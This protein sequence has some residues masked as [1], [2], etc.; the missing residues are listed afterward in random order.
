MAEEVCPHC[1]ETISEETEDCP[2]CGYFFTEHTCEK[3]QHRE[4]DGHC[5][6][7]GVAVCEECNKPQSR[8]FVCEAHSEIPL[9]SGWAQVY[10]AQNDVE[11]EL[12]RENLNA[13]G[14]ESRVL[15][16]QDHNVFAVGIGELNQV[17]VLVPAYDYE[18]AHDLIEEHTGS[19][20]EVTFACPN[21]GEPYDADQERCTACGAELPSPTRGSP[22]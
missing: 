13:E 3:H 22:A 4:A 2:A 5:V 12:I 14:V 16:Q 21:C 15:S 11:A 19:E 9:M 6:I 10:S 7:C 8:H 17:R 18:V 1:D 20:G